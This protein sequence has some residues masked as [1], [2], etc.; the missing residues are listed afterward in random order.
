[1]L[2][3]KQPVNP[4]FADFQPVSEITKTVRTSHI[5]IKL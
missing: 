4:G 5:E 1:M 2:I 3:S